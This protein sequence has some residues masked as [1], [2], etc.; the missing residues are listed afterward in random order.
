MKS[1]LLRLLAL[2]SI[3]AIGLH[4]GP[5]AA[6]G[7]ALVAGSALAH[8]SC[9]A[10]LLGANTFSSALVIDVAR[11]TGI[12]VLQ[13]KLSAL[14]AFSTDFA[15][16]E[17][18]PRKTIQVPKVVSGSTAVKNP[19]TYEGGGGVIDHIAVTPDEYSVPFGISSNELN[20][21][22][23][24]EQL[25]EINLQVL[26]NSIMDVATAPLTAANFGAAAVTVAQGDFG[27]DDFKTLYA[28]SKNY[29]RKNIVLDGG[30]L[31]QV[32]PTDRLK[33]ALTEAGAYGFDSMAM[34]NR[35][36]G[37][38]A[39]VVGFVADPQAVGLASGLAQIHPAVASLMLVNEVITVPGVNIAVRFNV[40]GST[41]TRA[42]NASYGLMFGA[43][44]GDTS[45]LKLVKSA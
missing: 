34:N 10:Y 1:L 9:P 45:A 25:F 5:L 39:N 16:D 11:K 29:N 15:A 6:L 24:L 40:W 31:A 37:A 41:N 4:Y 35:W 32:I 38:E 22:F 13:N 18:A 12:T 28:V 27:T 44:V 3:V 26:A 21:G 33:F 30:Y 20:Q 23:R 43:A 14:T 8:I 19:A 7:Y 36:N 17:V 42:I 2:V